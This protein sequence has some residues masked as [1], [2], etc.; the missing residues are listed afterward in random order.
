MNEALNRPEERN[1]LPVGIT[2]FRGQKDPALPI[3]NEKDFCRMCHAIGREN[4]RPVMEVDTSITGRNFY[5]GTLGGQDA[6]VF[7]LQNIHYPCGA[8]ARGDAFGTFTLIERPEGFRLPEGC[9]HFLSLTQLN[10][11]WR[12]LCG[13]LGVEE[14]EQ[15]Q[16]WKPQ[17]VGEIIFNH[18]D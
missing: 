14:W 8:F 15:I 13:E 7:L 10:R 3:L 11:D 18:W 9:V 12:G 6:P 17:T 16:Y 4:G 2:G 1:L 5:Y